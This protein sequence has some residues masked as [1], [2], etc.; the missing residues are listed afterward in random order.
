MFADNFNQEFNDVQS[1]N[2]IYS[3]LSIPETSDFDFI[4]DSNLVTECINT[5]YSK[6]F[7]LIESKELELDVTQMNSS[8]VRLILACKE[9]NYMNVGNI[10]CVYCDFFNVDYIKIF[11][12][13]HPNIKK[14]ITNSYKKLVGKEEYLLQ[15]SKFNTQN[16]KQSTIFDLFNHVKNN[17]EEDDKDEPFTAEEI[18]QQELEDDDYFT[19]DEIIYQQNLENFKY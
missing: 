1:L 19:E 16:Y 12:N 8:F 5:I 7:L 15:S 9:K 6:K 3:Q 13:L 18:K 11:N 2:S 10:F 4:S 17:V 14:I